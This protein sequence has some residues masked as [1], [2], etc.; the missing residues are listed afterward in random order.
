[1]PRETRP[2]TLSAV[3]DVRLAVGPAEVRRIGQERV[4]VVSANLAD[5]DL[6]SAVAALEQIVADAQLPVGIVAFLSGQ[7][8]EMSDSFRSLQFTML[9][10]AAC[11]SIAASCQRPLD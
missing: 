3:A 9:L 2:V 4:A 10:A 8:E 1:M 5:G 6:G 11:S 7:S